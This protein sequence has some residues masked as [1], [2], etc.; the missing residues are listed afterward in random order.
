MP[1]P[2]PA[3]EAVVFRGA[4][5]IDGD[6]GV[7]VE[8]SAF[9]VA[10]VRFTQVGPASAVDF[11]DGSR[12]VDLSGLTVMPAIIDTHTHLN[13]EREALIADLRD[14]ARFGVSAAM[15]LGRDTRDLSIRDEEILG[16]ARFRS[17]GVGITSPEP[18]RSEIPYWVTTVDEAR[19]AVREQ[20]A[21]RVDIIKS[22][23][24]SRHVP[25]ERLPLVGHSSILSTV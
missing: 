7:T 15:S 18:G 3:S 17:A 20:A 24:S 4:L 5:L 6:G 1:P 8:D 14:R 2:E 12:T 11:P 13:Q 25:L 19:E 16:A 9:L 10:E 23:P 22:N 21:R